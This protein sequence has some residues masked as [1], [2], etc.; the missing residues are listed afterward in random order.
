MNRLIVSALFVSLLCVA[1]FAQQRPPLPRGSQKSTV[2]QTLGTTEVS[3]TYSRP[4]VRG[5]TIW[6]DPPPGTPEGEAT[7]DDGRARPAGSPIVFWGKLW[8]TG[9]NEATLLTV[10]DDVLI[11]GQPLAAGKYSLHSIPGKDDWTFVFNKDDGQWGSFTYDKSKDALRVKSKPEWVADSKELLTFM[12]DPA[13]PGADGAAT[14]KGTVVLRWEKL[15][16]P[17]T[18]EVKD[19]VAATMTRLAAFVAAARPDDPA[20]ALSAANYAKQNKRTDEANRWY[21]QAI[22]ASDEQIKGKASFANLQRK[23]NIL[24]A[25]GRTADAIAAGERAI[26]AGKAEKV[27]TAALEKRVADWKAGKTN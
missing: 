25:A 1:A 2:A 5:R 13:P 3:I 27:D 7:L 17:F 22:K 19:T 24:V 15:R 4:A 20:P 21:E 6:G 14:T 11:N 9:A 26:E 8:R 12:I 16:V 10:A 23:V 18:V